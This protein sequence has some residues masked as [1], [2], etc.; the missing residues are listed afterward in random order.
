M[1]R[2]EQTIFTFHQKKR[3]YLILKWA[4]G[5]ISVKSEQ[6]QF[7]Y[8]TVSLEDGAWALWERMWEMDGYVRIVLD[9]NSRL[10]KRVMYLTIK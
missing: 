5:F 2:T 10:Q 3:P 1:P 9:Q 8:G 7:I 4:V 6:N